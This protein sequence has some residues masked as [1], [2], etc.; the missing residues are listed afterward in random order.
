MKAWYLVYTKPR[1]E[2]IALDNLERQ[3]YQAYLPLIRLQRHRKG[4]NVTLT[5]PMF[6]R[7][8]FIHLGTGTDN[9]GPIRSTLGVRELVRF[10]DNPAKIPEDFIATLKGREGKEG[11]YEA[12]MP[13]L[14]EGN[15]VR[16]VTGT[17]AGYQ[18]IFC[19]KTSKERV[20]LLLEIAGRP[21]RLQLAADHIEP[22]D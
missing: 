7:Y 16:I 9:W 11:V 18:A 14:K 15:T 13:S 6:P 22:I 12:P 20:I 19:A 4:R 5:E 17:M 10:G 3:G 8:L 2:R 21:V 1:Q